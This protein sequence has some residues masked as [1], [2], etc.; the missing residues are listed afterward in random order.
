MKLN[1]GCGTDVRSGYTN[2]DFRELHGVDRVVDL[3]LFP[4]PFGT[5]ECEEVLMLDFLEHFPYSV[6]DR[7]LVECYRI[8]RPMGELVIQ[9]PDAEILGRVLSF[10][11]S[12]QCNRCGRWMNGIDHHRPD[13]ECPKCKQG[14]NSIQEAAMMRMFGGQDHPGNF[15]HTC[16]TRSMLE[17]RCLRVGLSLISLEEQEH[18]AANWNFKVRFGKG[19]L[20]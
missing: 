18:Q 14:I 11:D 1:L 9:V 3:S 7:L 2:V 10:R 8:L 12:F 4:W 15:H 17:R 16:F 5:E 19:D 6:T 20:W 13:H